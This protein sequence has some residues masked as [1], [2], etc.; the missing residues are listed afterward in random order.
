MSKSCWADGPSTHTA[1]LRIRRM[2]PAD[3]ADLLEY[4]AHPMVDRFRTRSPFTRA[5]A[6]EFIAFPESLSLGSEEWLYLAVVLQSEGKMI[7]TVCTREIS[8]VHRQGEMGWFLN[9]AYHGRGFATEAARTM[10]ELGFVKLDLHRMTARC[11]E[12][13]RPS[14]RLI[15]RLGMRREALLHE[16]ACLDGVW[17][18]ELVYAILKS[19]WEEQRL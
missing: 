15:E 14:T 3:L 19:A 4:D 5:E 8:E 6:R 11:Y 17:H 13:N 1:R 10:L 9:P 16:T 12:H 2:E 18:N 7:G